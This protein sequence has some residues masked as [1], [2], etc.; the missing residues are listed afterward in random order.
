MPIEANAVV[1]FI[2]ALIGW[3]IFLLQGRPGEA[4]AVL[5]LANIAWCCF[6]MLYKTADSEDE[7]ET[8]K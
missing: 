8:K 7:A 5:G 3:V 4:F 6:R 1:G 2:S